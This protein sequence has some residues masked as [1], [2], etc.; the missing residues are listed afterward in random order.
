[1][2]KELTVRVRVINLK[3]Q[4]EYMFTL[5]L[6]TY[7][8]VNKLYELR[9]KGDVNPIVRRLQNQDIRDDER[10][11]LYFLLDSGAKIG[12]LEFIE[13]EMT[14]RQDPTRLIVA[15]WPLPYK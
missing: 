12:T 5:P 7:Q 10:E 6:S 11:L 2:M 3:K 8:Y 13:L 14:L 9:E 1:M 15:N 4:T